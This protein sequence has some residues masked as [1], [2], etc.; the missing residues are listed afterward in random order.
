MLRELAEAVLC[1]VGGD[2]INVLANADD[3]LLSCAPTW[4]ALQ[5]LINPSSP[6]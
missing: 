5:C 1:N 3:L 6:V 4:R 2:I